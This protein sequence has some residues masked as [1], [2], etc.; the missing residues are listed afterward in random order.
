MGIT[1]EVTRSRVSWFVTSINFYEYCGSQFFWR[2]IF[3]AGVA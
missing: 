2:E 3:C 1:L